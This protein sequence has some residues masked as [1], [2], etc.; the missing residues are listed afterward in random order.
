[1]QQEPNRSATDCPSDPSD[2]AEI[3]IRELRQPVTSQS[4]A[5]T[6]IFRQ[7]LGR[8]AR[9]RRFWVALFLAIVIVMMM[10]LHLRGRLSP[11]KMT[12]MVR[13]YP[14][15]APAV[16]FAVYT[17]MVVAL[18]P[19]LPLN[20][21][22]GA[23]WGSVFGSMLSIS[24]AV[25]GASISFVA[26]RYLISGLFESWF[27]AR[28]WSWL[29]WGI[30]SADWKAVAFVRVNPVFPF[31]PLNYFFGATGI[32]FSRYFWTTLIFIAP[33]SI[34]IAAIGDAIGGFVLRDSAQEWMQNVFL[35]SFAVTAIVGMRYGLRYWAARNLQ[36][37]RSVTK[38]LDVVV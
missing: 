8:I 7:T 37:T 36:T 2:V 20:M 29:K 28:A 32:R 15:V 3:S 34:V 25:A 1:M 13:D 35:V 38:D 30:A 18:L 12:D 14:V 16:F 22:A 5:Q 4:P 27:E 21:A 24:A 10:A 23:L 26:S 17:I 19:T 6:K 33:P 9:R 11:E 31:G